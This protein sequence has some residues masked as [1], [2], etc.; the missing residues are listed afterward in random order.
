MVSIWQSYKQEYRDLFLILSKK[1]RDCE[2][3][4]LHSLHRT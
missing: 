4:V 2:G 3:F 1:G